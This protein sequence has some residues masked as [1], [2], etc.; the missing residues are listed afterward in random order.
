[1]L[2]L[3]LL[4][5]GADPTKLVARIKDAG[6]TPYAAV[7]VASKDEQVRSD[8]KGVFDVVVPVGERVVFEVEGITYR[9]ERRAEDTGTVELVLPDRRDTVVHCPPERCALK[10][11]WA[12]GPGF[13][14]VFRGECARGVELPIRAPVGAPAVRCVADE[15]QLDVQVVDQPDGLWIVAPGRPARIRVRPTDGGALPDA[16]VV[17][18]GQVPAEPDGPGAWKGT[19]RGETIVSATCDGRAAMP[20]LLREDQPADEVLVRWSRT[21]PTVDLAKAA[22]WA[23]SIVLRPEGGAPLQ[24]RSDAAV[25]GLPPLPAGSWRVEIAGAS[26]EPGEV[27]SLP[28]VV[29]GKLVVVPAGREWSLGALTLTAPVS[30]GPIPIR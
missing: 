5:C 21:G 15:A 18:L 13:E 28:P 26:S 19:A 17:L 12:L 4:A 20:V 27:V 14:A 24:V 22:P 16:C 6:G 1:M 23:R 25:F 2:A 11:D 29:P 3:T 30:E 8:S 9:R 10:L 7:L